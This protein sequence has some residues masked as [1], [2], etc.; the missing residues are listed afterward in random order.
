MADILTQPAGALKAYMREPIEKERIDKYHSRFIGPEGWKKACYMEFWREIKDCDALGTHL[1][2]R[3]AMNLEELQEL[4]E[5]EDPAGPSLTYYV[6]SK[7]RSSSA[8]EVSADRLYRTRLPV[9]VDDDLDSALELAERHKKVLM[10]E[11]ALF[12]ELRARALST[13]IKHVFPL[14]D[15]VMLRPKGSQ[16]AEL[17]ELE[18]KPRQIKAL[19]AKR[20]NFAEGVERE[21]EKAR[22]REAEAQKERDRVR[23]R[24]EAMSP[25][26]DMLHALA[27]VMFRVIKNKLQVTDIV[28]VEVF[29]SGGI[30][31]CAAAFRYI[32]S[33]HKTM[34]ML[35]IRNSDWLNARKLA[36]QLQPGDS[37][38]RVKTRKLLSNPAKY[39]RVFLQPERYRDEISFRDGVNAEVKFL[40]LSEQE[41]KQEKE[42]RAALKRGAYKVVFFSEQ[43]AM[44][45]R[46]KK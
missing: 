32:E 4:M 1:D 27:L 9:V 20:K 29:R 24:I 13:D 3:Y 11:A 44:Y 40:Q 38:Y 22:Q 15:A 12:S 17:W 5:T 23:Q 46:S 45:G 7:L 2:I 42:C 26:F 41:Q 43:M 35:H 18:C 36:R 31:S 16:A 33:A 28:S 39:L 25:I 8:D 14:S 10:P 19:R 34:K 21:R 30:E 37:T 6:S